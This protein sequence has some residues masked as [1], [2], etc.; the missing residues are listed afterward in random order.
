MGKTPKPLS[1]EAQLD[2]RNSAKAEWMRLKTMQ[3]DE[4]T[5]KRI[6]RFKTK[7]ANCEVVYKIIL[8]EY[9]HEKEGEYPDPRKMKLHMNQV[10]NALAFAGYDYDNSL[11]TKLFSAEA[12]VGRRSVKVIRDLLTHGMKQSAIDELLSRELEL[13]GYMDD[14]LGKIETFDEE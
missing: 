2:L 4:D 13:N 5:I 8:N 12:H 11:L 3:E 14:F 7:F 9:R 6:E 1:P 10:T